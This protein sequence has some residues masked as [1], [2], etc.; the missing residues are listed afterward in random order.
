MYYNEFI[1]GELKTKG[2][3]LVGFADLSELDIE[4][5]RR[6]KYGILIAIALNPSIV[7]RIPSGPHMDYY[8]EYK[9]V[10]KKL[11]DLSEYTAQIIASKG[12]QAFSQATI[13]SDDDYRTPL[14]HKT[15]AT[16]AGVGWIGKSA[17]LVNEQYGNAIRIN[18]ILTDMPFRTGTP[19]N[20]SKC[21]NCNICVTNCPGEAIKGENWCVETI[22]E[23]LFNAKVCK[24]EVIKRGIPFQLTEGTCGVCIAVCPYTQRYVQSCL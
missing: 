16:R 5:R 6:Y 11:K 18:S 4:I 19:I 14:P 7:S 8:D 2:A 20:S 15:V 1:S 22:R 10:S 3:T 12:F 17:T 21:G 24:N 23:E 9:S 13:K